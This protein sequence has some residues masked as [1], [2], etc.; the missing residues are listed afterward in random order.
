LSEFL[1]EA[2]LLTLLG[3]L[4]GVAAG[5]LISY[6]ISLAANKFGFAWEFSVP[7]SGILLGLGVASGIGL[8]FGV[9]PERKAAKL[10]PIEALRYE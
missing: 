3:G 7:V 10:D 5:A 8:V 9:F 6:G 4:L 1:V 2:V